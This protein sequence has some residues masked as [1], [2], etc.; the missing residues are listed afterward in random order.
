[1][2]TPPTEACG[3]KFLLGTRGTA[4]YRSAF[5]ATAAGIL[6]YQRPAAATNTMVINQDAGTILHREGYQTTAVTTADDLR[7]ALQQR[8]WDLV[9]VDAADSA[10]VPADQRTPL[11]PL[12]LPVLLKPTDAALTQARREF[13]LVLK[14]PLK[15]QAFLDAI[16]DALE[17]R[18]KAIE[19]AAKARTK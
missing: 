10:A 4:I 14:G 7:R 5:G 19:R 1:L 15:N 17:K 6:I 18:Y 3:D 8:A 11:A 13:S 12:V 16:G 9:I 2:V